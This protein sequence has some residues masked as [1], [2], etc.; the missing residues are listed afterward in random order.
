MTTIS[1][2]EDG[3]IQVPETNEDLQKFLQDERFIHYVCMA[4]RHGIGECITLLEFRDYRPGTERNELLIMRTIDWCEM[5]WFAIS[6]PIGEKHLMEAA[7][8][9]SGLRVAN[10]IPMMFGGTEV[11][12]FPMCNKRVFTL[13]NVSGHP[14]YRNDKDV[15]TA[16]R[17]GE[18]ESIKRIRETLSLNFPLG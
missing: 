13:E 16:L 17:E 1:V 18:Y 8:R 9:E 4:M 2:V 15:D 11:N 12:Q 14:I 5:P 10:G 3:G 7:A 6:I